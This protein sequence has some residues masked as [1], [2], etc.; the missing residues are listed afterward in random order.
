MKKTILS[1][2]VVTLF[3]IGFAASS[4]KEEVRYDD[5]GRKYHK[6][7]AKCYNCGTENPYHDY[8]EDDNGNKMGFPLGNIL[9]NGHYYCNYCLS[10]PDRITK[11]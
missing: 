11:W 6:V 4:E 7:R 10:D 8:W 5:A 1:M 3:A 2:A 9:R